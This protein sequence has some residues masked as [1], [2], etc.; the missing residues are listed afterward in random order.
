MR[1]FLGVLGIIAF[2][3]GL[4]QYFISISPDGQTHAL[5]IIGIGAI[6]L[7]AEGIIAAIKKNK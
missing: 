1:Y 7:S 3:V 2:F 4:A 6:C 5:I